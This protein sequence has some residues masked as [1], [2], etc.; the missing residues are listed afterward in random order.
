MCPPCLV[1]GRVH[2]SALSSWFVNVLVVT[3][4]WSI[5]S[6]PSNSGI[7]ASTTSTWS[8][9]VPAEVCTG[10]SK[11]LL[12][13]KID[14]QTWTCSQSAEVG[15]K[16]QDTCKAFEPSPSRKLSLEHECP[17][18]IP[19]FNLVEVGVNRSEC[20]FESFEFSPIIWQLYSPRLFL[21]IRFPSIWTTPLWRRFVLFIDLHVGKGR[22]FI[23]P[24]AML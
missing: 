20:V 2:P 15:T 4:M 10:T 23:L 19:L 17:K 1:R 16:F 11:P 6:N 14:P 22:L 18:L 7:S 21:G 8:D 3:F 12:N 9:R 5:K 24:L 13:N